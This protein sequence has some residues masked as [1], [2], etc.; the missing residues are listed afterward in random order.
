MTPALDLKALRERLTIRGRDGFDYAT[1]YAMLDELVALRAALAAIHLCAER[2]LSDLGLKLDD[3][4][5]FTE[6]LV[7]ALTPSS[8]RSEG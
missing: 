7:H 4:Q 3:E 5:A 8:D 1:I 6:I 2:Q